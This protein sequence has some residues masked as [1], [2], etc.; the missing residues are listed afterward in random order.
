MTRSKPKY[1]P[2]IQVRC[3][4]C[5]IRAEL[6]ERG[7]GYEEHWPATSPNCRCP[8]PESCQSMKAAFARACTLG[9][10]AMGY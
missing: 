1:T 6:V 10:P 3:G 5:Y 4:D 8:P 9:R 7:S 2:C